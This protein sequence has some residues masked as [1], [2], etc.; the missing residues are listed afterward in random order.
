MLVDQMNEFLPIILYGSDANVGDDSSSAQ[1]VTHETKTVDLMDL[2]G[3]GA[4]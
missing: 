3:F 4:E 2:P 1:R